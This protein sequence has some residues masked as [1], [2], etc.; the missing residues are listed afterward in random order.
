M[1]VVL[2]NK[3][4]FFAREILT[5]IAFCDIFILNKSHLPVVTRPMR[6]LSRVSGCQGES[7]YESAAAEDGDAVQIPQAALSRRGG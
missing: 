1:F 3:K 4:I 6:A 7:I 2:F 5:F